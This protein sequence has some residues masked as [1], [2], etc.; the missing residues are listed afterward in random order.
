MEEQRSQVYESAVDKTG[1]HGNRA[2][3]HNGLKK[4][5]ISSLVRRGIIRETGGVQTGRCTFISFRFF[6]L[7][8]IAMKVL[9]GA[10]ISKQTMAVA[11]EVLQF[12]CSVVSIR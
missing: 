1:N 6:C 11:G 4:D 5:D 12:C 3:R 2:G 9:N 10:H 8:L 7:V